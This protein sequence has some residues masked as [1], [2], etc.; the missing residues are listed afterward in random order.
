MIRNVHLIRQG[1]NNTARWYFRQLLGSV[2][3]FDGTSAR[4]VTNIVIAASSYP[5]A[6]WPLA[7]QSRTPSI[8]RQHMKVTLRFGPY[9][10]SGVGVFKT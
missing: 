5:P 8:Y 4:G 10:K 1:C 9:P 7:N 2:A 6:F 3:D